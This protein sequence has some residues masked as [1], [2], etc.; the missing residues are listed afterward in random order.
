MFQRLPSRKV[1]T[2]AIGSSPAAVAASDDRRLELRGR[3]RSSL[4]AVR[5]VCPADRSLPASAT[6]GVTRPAP[7]PP[8]PDCASMV[9]DPILSRLGAT[10]GGYTLCPRPSLRILLLSRV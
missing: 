5:S 3:A 9:P 10:R 4:L 2:P 7:I 8:F 1:E 6:T